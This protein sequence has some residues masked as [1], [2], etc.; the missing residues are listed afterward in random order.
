MVAAAG[1]AWLL[2]IH[3]I[4]P[5]PPYL[6]AKISRRLQ[7]IGA[8][9]VKNSVYVLPAGPGHQETFQWLAREIVKG[10]G[11]AT[12]CDARFVD[13]LNDEAVRRM[14]NDARDRDYRAVADEA[15][16]SAPLPQDRRDAESARLR[17]RLADLKEIDF[18]GALGRT[19]AEAAVRRLEGGKKDAAPAEGRRLST[20]DHRARTWV[21]R[22]GVFVDRIACAWLIRNFIDP[23]A[24]FKFVPGK[25]YGPKPGELRFD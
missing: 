21:T 11:E 14:F 17:Q 25:S 8:V 5:K 1:P 13:G 18:F 7:Q 2:L 4:P 20:G 9:A 15:R 10:K 23:K 16:G 12:I 22:K 19:A 3:Q 6:R 24:R